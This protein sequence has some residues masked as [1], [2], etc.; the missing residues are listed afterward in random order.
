MGCLEQPLPHP[1]PGIVGPP[2]K[3]ATKLSPE[4]LLWEN[5]SSTDSHYPLAQGPGY[6]RT[7]EGCSK[8]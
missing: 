7:G 8:R 2:Q 3:T 1:C 4:F 6:K 5:R